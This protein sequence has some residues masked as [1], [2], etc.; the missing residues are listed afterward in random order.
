M[1]N[2]VPVQTASEAKEWKAVSEM[3][4]VRINFPSTTEDECRIPDWVDC[5]TSLEMLLM[6]ERTRS[7]LY[8]GIIIQLAEKLI[9]AEAECQW[10]GAVQGWPNSRKP[11]EYKKHEESAQEKVQKCLNSLIEREVDKA[12]QGSGGYWER[13]FKA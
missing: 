3:Q 5:Q 11:E 12:Q 4:R 13:Y 8:K 7:Q 6:A 2:D 10:L 1:E 9:S